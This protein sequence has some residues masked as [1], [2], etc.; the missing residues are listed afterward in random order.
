MESS[1]K[2]KWKGTQGLVLEVQI[3]ALLF[4]SCISWA[5][6]F[7]FGPVFN[8]KVG[9]DFSQ[10]VSQDFSSIYLWGRECQ[11]PSPIW[12]AGSSSNLLRHFPVSLS[13]PWPQLHSQ[14]C[15]TR[16]TTQ[17]IALFR[18]FSS[19]FCISLQ[20]IFLTCLLSGRVKCWINGCR[21]TDKGNGMLPECKLWV[22]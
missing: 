20:Q 3:L 13:T 2:M 9:T 22:I 12:F 21:H 16:A 17:S 14:G 19:R 7:T 11:A 5:A 15:C 18:L 10:P 6:S 1:Q 4:I 8:T